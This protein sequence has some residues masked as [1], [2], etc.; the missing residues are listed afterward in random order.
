ML[1]VLR[2]RQREA[3]CQ[4]ILS[5]FALHIVGGS[6]LFHE[7]DVQRSDPTVRAACSVSGSLSHGHG[8]VYNARSWAV[9]VLPIVYDI[10]E[11]TTHSTVRS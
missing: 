5:V 4:L 6:K 8:G 11:H 3:A 9:A 1:T 10:H 7:Y 2:H